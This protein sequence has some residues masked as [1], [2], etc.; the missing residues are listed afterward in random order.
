MFY[1]RAAAMAGAFSFGVA[2]NAMLTRIANRLSNYIQGNYPEAVG[3]PTRQDG[4]KKA[5]P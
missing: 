5:E 4:P 3:G 1:A 2:D